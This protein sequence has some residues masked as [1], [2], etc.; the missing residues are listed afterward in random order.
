PVADLWG[1]WEHD[2]MSWA[3]E[4]VYCGP[5]GV[6]KTA[7]IVYWCHSMCRQYPGLRF[8]WTRKERV[9]MTQ[10]VLKTFRKVL[11]DPM[12]WLLHRYGE[13]PPEE[14]V[15]AARKQLHH[16]N[17]YL[18]EGPSDATR[19]MY[20]YRRPRGYYGPPSEIVVAG[21]GD[22]TRL[23]S[24]EY[25]GGFVNESK[26]CLLEEWEHL[27]RALRNDGPGTV[28]PLIGDTNPGPPRHWIPERAKTGRLNLVEVDW[29]DNPWI[30]RTQEGAA[31]KKDI[32]ELY[33]GHR[34]RRNYY[35]EWCSAEGQ[36]YPEWEDS[37]HLVR[38]SLEQDEASGDWSLILTKGL[39]AT[40]DKVVRVPLKRFFAGQDWGWTNPG[41]QQVWAFDDKNRVFLVRQHHHSEKPL[42][43]WAEVAEENHK[44]F[45][46]Q[47]IACDP[48]SPGNIE[49]FN[50][51]LGVPRGRSTARIA[52]KGENS[53]E[54]GIDHVRD[55]LMDA[56]D[57]YPRLFVLENSLAHQ[58]D[59]IL[60][61]RNVPT[62]M[63][64]EIPAYVYEEVDS[65]KP[66]TRRDQPM[67]KN[68]HGMDAMRYAMA[69]AWRRDPKEPDGGPLYPPGSWG[70]ML[71]SHK[72]R[73]RRM[74][75]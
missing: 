62:C 1:D 75:I 23:Y 59:P 20:T 25:W 15:E 73:R 38:G 55:R 68:D 36:V 39:G 71:S 21:L 4:V 61:Q 26:E 69:W 33:T 18:F 66:D 52:I 7:Q 13:S 74:P 5:V 40:L 24:S 58:P 6:A 53:I 16:D 42:D 67:K 70:D 11:L 48:S 14:L 43:W 32:R 37:K 57:G 17:G 54:A 64:D 28:H 63:Q 46:L 44:L 34:L 29:A 3:R 45:G 8:L 47:P 72:K 35:G 10:A 2:D 56:E 9:R 31:Y 51:R 41:S 27:R 12:F 65:D 50:D 30:I 49:A 22:D 60:V 19:E